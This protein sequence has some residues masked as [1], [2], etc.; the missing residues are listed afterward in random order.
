MRLLECK[1]NGDLV[2]REFFGPDTPVYA[3]LSHTWGDE[4]V[5]FR[6]IEAGIGKDKLG[7]KKIEF[8]RNKAG[9][10]GIRYVWVDTCCIDKTNAVELQEAIISMF[11]WYKEAAECFVYMSDV[12]MG[13]SG[14]QH[15]H[16]SWETNFR[17]SRWFRR[18][19]TLQELVAPT[20]VTFFDVDGDR[21]GTRE[22]LLQLIHE[23][24]LIP[25]TV[26]RGATLTG[27]GVNERMLWAAGR[28]TTRP[29]DMAYSLLGIFG[30]NMPV[31]YGEGMLE[32]FDRLHRE[33]DHRANLQESGRSVN[34]ILNPHPVRRNYRQ[35]TVTIV[36]YECDH[37]DR[38][39]SQYTLLIPS[40]HCNA[41]KSR[42]GP[43]DFGCL[44]EALPL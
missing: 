27:Y 16:T 8:V 34:P 36:S 32:A 42:I 17:Q 44:P 21:L 25:F 29:E 5:S 33:I 7:W 3:I 10:C 39:V 2:P 31:L 28:A 20:S 9:A 41:L 13:R 38:V 35:V 37:L 23:I 4:E 1:P 12:S 26:L 18:G 15:S 6:E 22:D 40:L 43:K 30:I 11:R 14:V 24:T 19:W